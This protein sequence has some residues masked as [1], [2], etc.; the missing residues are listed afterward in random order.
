MAGRQ[1]PRERTPERRESVVRRHLEGDS[2]DRA[3]TPAPPKK[4]SRK[5]LHLAIPDPPSPEI[6]PDSDEEEGVV[7]GVGFSYPPVKIIEQ[8]DGTR[9]FKKMSK[10]AFPKPS[11]AEEPPKEGTSGAVSNP[12]SKPVVSAWEKGMAI[13]HLL[14]DKYKIDK[15]DRTGFDFMPQ[16]FIVYRKICNT[17]LNEDWKYCP[18]TFTTQK[19]FGTM[20]G[21][22]LNQYVL[23]H[24]GIESPAWKTKWEP[25]G[26]AVWN[27]RSSETEGKLMCLHGLP[28]IAK[29]HIVEMDVSSEAGQRALKETPQR[30][31]V[32]QNRWGRNVVQLRHE[33]ARCCMYDV[34]C[35]TN[36]FSSKSCG[37]FYSEGA[38][39]QQAF[40]QIEAFMLAAYPH[41]TRGQKHL[42]MPLRCECNYLGDGIP[43]A[44]RQLCKI[45]PFA[46]PNA[47]DMNTGDITDPVAL[48]SLNYPSLLVFQCAN[49]SYRNTRATNQINCDF[50][51]SA[52]DLLL[53][54]QLVRTLWHDNF[55]ELGLPKLMLPEFKWEPRFQYKNLTLPT[56]H[57]DYQ[58]NPF[59][60]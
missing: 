15:D 32:T 33:D 12:I 48:A 6:I 21:R 52:P 39:A 47:E 16:S 60:F 23:L 37:M 22:F 20:M 10:D 40:K 51:I 13:M 54:L 11:E 3:P 1:E 2:P 50:K 53:A 38:K 17:W 34:N 8:S 24:A 56:S 28:M 25:T 18:L 45:T 43:R 42:L 59:E 57:L 58:E 9:V 44:G 31:K 5:S 36:V 14:M 49:P 26:C 46:V 41:M 29:E 27:H 4:K 30:A 55:V 35:A 7:V 19:T